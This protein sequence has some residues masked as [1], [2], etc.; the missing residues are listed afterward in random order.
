MAL[1]F[2]SSEIE[3]T[4]GLC[5]RV[6]IMF[7]GKSICEFQKGEATKVDVALWVSGGDKTGLH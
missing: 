1:L 5:D 7:R 2:T 4:I 3:E 6:R